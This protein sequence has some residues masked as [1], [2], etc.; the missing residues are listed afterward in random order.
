ML[1]E[2]VLSH[3]NIGPCGAASLA[4]AIAKPGYCKLQVSVMNSQ[5]FFIS[6][7]NSTSPGGVVGCVYG[8][9]GPS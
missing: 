4:D 2:L 9:V 7:S 5:H 1:R 3:G 8:T 6:D